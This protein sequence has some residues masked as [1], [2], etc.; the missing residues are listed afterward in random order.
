MRHHN[1]S[2]VSRF[3]HRRQPGH[4]NMPYQL[5]YVKSYQKNEFKNLTKKSSVIKILQFVADRDNCTR[6]EI[7][8]GVY[9]FKTV[10]DARAYGRGFNSAM[11]AQLLYIDLIDYDKNFRY[12]ITEK[13]R[14]VLEQSYINDIVKSMFTK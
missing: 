5:N 10:E 9:G 11:Y 3:S 8:V 1:P 14:K 13:G 12:H 2:N 4:L 6:A 7:N